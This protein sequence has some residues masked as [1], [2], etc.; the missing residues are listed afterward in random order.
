MP[1]FTVEEKER[2]RETLKR[3]LDALDKELG[4]SAG[5]ENGGLEKKAAQEDTDAS[6]F[7]RLSAS[8]EITQIAAT[9]PA[10]FAQLVEA[11]RLQGERSLFQRSIP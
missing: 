8:G 2:Q 6:L 9:D 11:K 7:D 10:R 4:T 5:G 1:D 3:H